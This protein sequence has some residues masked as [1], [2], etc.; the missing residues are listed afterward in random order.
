MTSTI[1]HCFKIT[2]LSSQHLIS[3]VLDES[4]E[5]IAIDE[6]QA[7]IEVLQSEPIDEHFT[8]LDTFE[9]DIAHDDSD[10]EALSQLY[11]FTPNE[12]SFLL[13]V[14]R[15]LDL[16]TR[17][18]YQ[19]D[20]KSIWAPDPPLLYRKRNHSVMEKITDDSLAGDNSRCTTPVRVPTKRRR[21]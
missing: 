17:L 9:N 2:D 5:K 4:F 21:Q 12:K 1:I 19:C 15:I 8:C 10:T 11:G 7:Y 13:N 18:R 3:E 6:P 14:N 16:K 20:P